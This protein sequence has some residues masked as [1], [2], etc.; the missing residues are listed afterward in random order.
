VVG[1]AFTPQVLD[2]A[3]PIR[4]DR[5]YAS[6][7]GVTVRRLA[8]DARYDAGERGVSVLSTDLTVGALGLDLAKAVQTDLHRELRRRSGRRTPSDPLGWGNQVSD[9]GEPTLLYRVM[10]ERF[11]AGDAPSPSAVKHAQL[12]WNAQGNLGYYTNVAAGL[13]GRAGRFLANFWDFNSNPLTGVQQRASAAGGRRPWEAYAFAGVR[14]RAV[15]YNALLQG[16][17]RESAHAFSAS[18]IRRAVGE[19]E[20]GAAT[21]LP[22]FGGSLGV[23]WTV[24]AGRTP[25]FRGPKSRAHAWGAVHVSYASRLPGQT[26]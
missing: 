11:L 8:V 25:E 16:Q 1:T 20:A 10:Y 15:A 26:R 2:E 12:T 13:S 6:V 19:G 4:D 9:G 22:V 7:V 3:R 5:P 24:V 14:G 17:F 23:N 18:Q 21:S